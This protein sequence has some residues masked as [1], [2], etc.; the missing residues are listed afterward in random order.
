VRS[1][2]DLE[3]RNREWTQMERAMDADRRRRHSDAIVNSASALSGSIAT[4]ISQ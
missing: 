1:A 2:P 3:V 4:S